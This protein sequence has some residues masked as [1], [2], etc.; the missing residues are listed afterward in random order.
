MTK[1]TFASI[2]DLFSQSIDDLADLPSFEV[3]PPGFYILD[4]TTVVKTVNDNDVI[5]AD[6]TVVETVEL[7]DSMSTAPVAAGTRFGILF[8]LNNKFGIGKL[9]EFLKPF[10][11]HFEENSIERLVRDVISGVRISCEVKNRKDK[12]D[13]DRVYATVH[14][15]TVS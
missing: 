11:E 10:G 15:I 13:P 8:M 7:S 4:V 12:N 2:D 1:E 6:F 5:E 14:G 3:P 9:K